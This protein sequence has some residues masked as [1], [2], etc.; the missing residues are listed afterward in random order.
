LLATNQRTV[1]LEV[2]RLNKE[3][4]EGTQGRNPRKKSKEGRKEGRKE[5][6][7]ERYRGPSALSHL[8][9]CHSF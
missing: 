2:R 9:P 1:I 7:Q 3:L 8:L 4:K 5:G 6:T